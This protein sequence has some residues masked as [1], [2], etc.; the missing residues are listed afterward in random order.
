MVAFVVGLLTTISFA[1]FRLSAIEDEAAVITTSAGPG[2]DRLTAVRG[3]LRR[4]TTYPGTYL[5]WRVQGTPLT[6]G[7][8]EAARARLLAEWQEYQALPRV[9]GDGDL[10]RDLSHALPALIDSIDAAVALIEK[11]EID[12]A[13][14]LWHRDILQSIDRTDST[15][16]HLV[17]FHA[18]YARSKAFEIREVRRQALRITVALG[19][20]SIFLAGVA[21]VLA[22]ITLNRQARLVAERNHL[23]QVRAEELEQFASRVAHDIKSPLGAVGLALHVARRHNP[24]DARTQSVTTRA[25]SSLRRVQQ[26]T[27][28]LLDFA[29]AGARPV[30][31][32]SPICNIVDDVVEELRSYAEE[33]D[34]TLTV[35]ASRGLWVAASAGAVVSLVSNLIS[36]AIKFTAQSA[37]RQVTVRLLDR[38]AC[39]RFEVDDTGP[40]I[41]SELRD[42]IFEP[43]V[44]GSN[45]FEPGIGLGLAT[46]KRLAEAHAGRAGVQLRTGKGSSFWFEL[47]KAE[48]PAGD[49]HPSPPAAPAA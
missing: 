28:G 6:K 12:A 26:I 48:P 33:R 13:R 38:G 47:P 5:V 10:F 4:L 43:Y 36:N 16:E 11:G 41:S 17:A 24:D 1:Q 29:R 42:L 19:T 2:I 27:D 21:T 32:A 30:P 34:V 25:L 14:A 44:R 7:P 46:V 20:I 8:H 15:V 9:T 45:A 35:Q 39:V 18:Q 31:A 49:S 3:E 22:F 23:T 40:G 37:E